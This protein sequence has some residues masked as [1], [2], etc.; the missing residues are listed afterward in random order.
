MNKKVEIHITFGMDDVD[1]NYD[2]DAIEDEL[3]DA[4]DYF[5]VISPT[6]DVFVND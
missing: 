2:L 1:E 6:I 4:L 5:G 3:V